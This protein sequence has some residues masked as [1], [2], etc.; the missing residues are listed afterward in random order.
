MQISQESTCVGVFFNKVAGPRNVT[1]LKTDQ[2]RLFPVKFAKF[3]RAPCFTEHFQWLLLK[4]SGF[5]PATLWKK[6]LRKKDFPANFAKFLK[7][8]F[9]LAEQLRMTSSCVHLWIL[10]GFSEHFF[11]IEHLGETAISCTSCR[12]STTRYSKKLFHR[13]F[14]SILYKIEK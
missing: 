13:C 4:V 5:Q 14:S 1:L 6:R 12:I 7:T 9:L 8:S 2:H 11:Y 3:L 10:R